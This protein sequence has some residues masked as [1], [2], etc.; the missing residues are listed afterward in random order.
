MI[1]RI[2]LI[3]LAVLLLLAFIGKLR[4]P[5]RPERPAVQKACKC[6]RCGAYVVGHAPCA[7]PG[8]GEA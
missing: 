7:S 3:G 2:V 8:C 5:K 4:L 1:G 6:P